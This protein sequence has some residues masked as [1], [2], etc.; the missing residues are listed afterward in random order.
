M[1]QIMKCQSCGTYTLKENCNKCKI[2]TE[3]PKPPKYSP[4]DKYGKY[5]RV[6][7]KDIYEKDGLI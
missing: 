5:R 1:K 4:D 2:P 7:K 3:N 6:A